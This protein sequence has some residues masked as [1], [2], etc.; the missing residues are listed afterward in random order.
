MLRFCLHLDVYVSTAPLLHP[1]QSPNASWALRRTKQVQDADRQSAKA[2]KDNPVPFLPLK[3][4]APT[5]ALK[6][7]C[8]R[9]TFPLH[10][11]VDGLGVGLRGCRPHLAKDGACR[12]PLFWGYLNLGCPLGCRPTLPATNVAPHRVFL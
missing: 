1:R 7:L 2:P 3:L 12:N 11:L 6:I 8:H 4:H 10:G 9:I 5:S